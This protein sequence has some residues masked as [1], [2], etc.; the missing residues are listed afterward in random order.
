MEKNTAYATPVIGSS[1][2]LTLH[3][4]LAVKVRRD[5][6]WIVQRSAH[7]LP[8]GTYRVS[9]NQVIAMKEAPKLKK[10]P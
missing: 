3:R 7:P 4:P 6:T 9:G 5:G 2:Y 10:R 1:Q 8:A